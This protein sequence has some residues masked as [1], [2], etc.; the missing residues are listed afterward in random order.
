PASGR[1]LAMPRLDMVTGLFF[2]TKMVEDEPGAGK[3][4]S[5]PAE[6]IMAY[7][8]KE[9]GLHAPVKIRISDRQPPKELEDK[10][11][12]RGWEQGKHRRAEP[13][14]GRVLFNGLLPPA[15]PFVIEVM[16]KKAHDKTVNGPAERYSIT[17]V[18]QT[19]DKI[20]DAGFYWAT[21]SGVT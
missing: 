11:A 21:R 20:K 4:F 3:A 1:P 6:A 8:L 7:D 13:P 14:L 10:L 12:E 5:S 2:L 19:L 16:Q 15:Y 9:I 18:A 17:Q